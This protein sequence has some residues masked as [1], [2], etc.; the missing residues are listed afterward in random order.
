MNITKKKREYTPQAKVVLVGGVL[1]TILNT[2]LS[3]S[4]RTAIYLIIASTLGNI[5]VALPVAFVLGIIP[6]LL[7]RKR[8]KDPVIIVFGIAYF[9]TMI[10]AINGYSHLSRGY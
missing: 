1:I 2:I 10:M 4:G 7:L 3:Y 8:I 5:I 6:Y 9:I